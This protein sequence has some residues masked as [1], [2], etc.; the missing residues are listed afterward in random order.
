MFV[1]THAHLDF[2]PAGRQGV[3]DLERVI[4]RAKEA[5]IGKVICI[6]TSVDASKKC[7]EI[8]QKYST[9]DFEIY[10]TCGIHPED[11]KDDIKKYGQNY[12]DEL[13]KVVMSSEKVVGIGEC[14]LDYYFEGDKRDVTGEQDKKIQ[15]GLFG[16]QIKLAKKLKLPLI[17]HCRNGWDSVFDL[18]ENIGDEKISGVFHSWTGDLDAYKKAESL[19]FYISFSGILTFKNAPSVVEVAKNAAIDNIVLETDSPFLSP[20]PLR[21]RK[22]EPKNVRIIAEFLAN[23]RNSSLKKIEDV[24]SKN[25]GDLF[26]LN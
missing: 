26:K 17:V 24:T 11:G 5:G 7:V 10:A 23:L 25:A 2:L 6:G 8:A 21:G 13:E 18:I 3:D 22:N 16:A 12:I 4:A 9:Q 15:I 14:G 19:G 1:D 20:E